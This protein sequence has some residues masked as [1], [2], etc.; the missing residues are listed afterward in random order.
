[1]KENFFDLFD[2]TSFFA[3]TFLNFLARCVN[4]GEPSLPKVN[5]VKNTYNDVIYGVGLRDQ[6]ACLLHGPLNKGLALGLNE[7]CRLAL[8]DPSTALNMV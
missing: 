3:W 6:G 1:M 2:F 8:P 5:C 7:G 4:L